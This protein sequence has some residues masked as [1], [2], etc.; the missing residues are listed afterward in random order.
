MGILKDL[1][2]NF[3]G[4]REKSR[5]EAEEARIRR[6]EAWEERRKV[7]DYISKHGRDSYKGKY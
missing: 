2:E 4:G 6:E 5:K 7:S 3:N 1:K